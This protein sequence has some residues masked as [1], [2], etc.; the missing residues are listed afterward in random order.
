M[1]DI[2]TV[3]ITAFVPSRDLGFGL[4]W[5]P[6]DLAYLRQ[7]NSSFLLQNFYKREHADNFMMHLPVEDVEAWRSHVQAQKLV[8][9]YGVR[10][11]SPADR[12]WGDSRL[13]DH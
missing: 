7:G 12:P 2:T 11:E 6:E 8:A 5:T 1:S 3:E 9:K 10:A 4:A 13:R